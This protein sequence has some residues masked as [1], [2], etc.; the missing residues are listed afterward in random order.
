MRAFYGQIAMSESETVMEWMARVER[1][2]RDVLSKAGELAWLLRQSLHTHGHR[3]GTLHLLGVPTRVLD[4]GAG[5]G[6]LSL[7][8]AWLLGDSADVIAVDQ[9]GRS[10]ELLSEMAAL[11]GV[12][13][14]TCV[15][16]AYTLPLDNFSPDLTVS[17]FL[18]Q[19]LSQPQDALNEMVRVTAPGG[20]VAVVA[21]DDGIGVAEPPLEPP[22]QK[23][24]DAIAELQTRNGGN[25]QVGRHLYRMMREVGLV[26]LQVT[27]MPRVRLGTYHGRS[28]ELEDHQRLFLEEHRADLLAEGLITETAFSRA[29]AALSE[30]FGEDRFEF[31]SE[32]L[33]IGRVPE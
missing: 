27:V 12:S 3:L 13:V 21:V 29:M 11:L 2:T 28:M 7:D 19:H 5:T 31:R 4:V 1:A 9:D 8:L 22:L 10:L 26:D 30:S 15:A 25:R 6:A 18:F 14:R 24:F 17:R 33:A 23:A 16:T 32:F 20:R